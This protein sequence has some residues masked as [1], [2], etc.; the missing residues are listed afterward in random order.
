MG[1]KRRTD[2]HLPQRMYCRRGAY[3][4]VDV[5]DRWHPLG[6]DYV[7]AMA[8]Y[9][10][11]TDPGRQCLTMTEVIERYRLHVT[12]HKAESTRKNEATQL[13]RLDAVFGELLPDEI[14]QQH[15]YR[16]MD[17]RSKFPTSANHDVTLL[18]HVFVKAIRWGAAT[19]NP[20]AGIEKTRSKPRDRYVTDQEFMAVRRMANVRVQIAMDIAL[21]TGL[22]RGDILSLTRDSLT[23][24]GLLVKS[25]KTG[26]ALLFEITPDLEEVLERAKKLKPQV[27]GFYLIRTMQGKPYSGSGFSAIWQR[28]M[29]KAVAQG[30][31]RFSFHDIRAKSASDSMSLQEASDRLG[32]ASKEMTHRV[33]MRTPTKVKPLK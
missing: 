25:Q 17:G 9:A 28:L 10:E 12:P 3:Y 27:P 16:Y 20:A 33:Y 19:K 5:A 26:K 22:R 8:K 14:T 11:M 1:R 4:F 18:H 6:R 23:D 21:L 7:Q 15:V 32:H 30:I 29:K 24:E 31:E 2:K 13:N